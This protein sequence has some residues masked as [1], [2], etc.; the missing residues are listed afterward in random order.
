MCLHFI[1]Q[2]LHAVEAE[3]SDTTVADSCC[4]VT[5]AKPVHQDSF[6]NKEEDVKKMMVL[7][8][9]QVFNVYIIKAINSAIT[10]TL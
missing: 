9:L 10:V 7:F 5:V 6:A 1:F 3:S 2:Q 8:S 4:T